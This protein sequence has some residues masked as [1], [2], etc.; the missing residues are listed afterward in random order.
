MC[1]GPELRMGAALIEHA[2]IATAAAGAVAGAGVK[3][4]RM[5]GGRQELSFKAF[6]RRQKGQAVLRPTRKETKYVRMCIQY[7]YI[8]F[9]CII[10]RCALM[11]LIWS[12]KAFCGSCSKF[13]HTLPT[14]NTHVHNIDNLLGGAFN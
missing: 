5:R 11:H 1:W 4:P 3:F 12:R 2:L 8:Y 7:I 14:L 9:L 13:Q 6:T 10:Y